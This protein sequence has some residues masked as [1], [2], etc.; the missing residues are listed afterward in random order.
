MINTI[1][2][3][4]QLLDLTFSGKLVAAATEPRPPE[5]PGGSRTFA[6]MR[7]GTAATER[8]PPESPGGSRR[9]PG[10][11]LDVAFLDISLDELARRIGASVCVAVRM[12]ERL[13]TQ[14][15]IRCVVDTSGAWEVL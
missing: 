8:R 15:R 1:P 14:G 9:T 13:N 3:R 5:S 11:T 10:S 4:K 12:V 6:T 2:F 7:A